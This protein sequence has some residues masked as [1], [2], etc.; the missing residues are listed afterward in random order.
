VAAVLRIGGGGVATVK[1]VSRQDG[2]GW[3]G[4]LQDYPDYWAQ[5]DTLDELKD[6]L[7]DL[8]AGLETWAT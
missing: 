2:D 4:Y 3:V 6:Q 5:G 7:R 8:Y 1:V